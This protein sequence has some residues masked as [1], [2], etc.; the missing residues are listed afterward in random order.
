MVPK[1]RARYVTYGLIT[2]LIQP[3]KKRAKQDEVSSGRGQSLLPI[4]HRNADRRPTYRQAA[5]QQHNIDARRKI[6]HNGYQEF[7]FVHAN[8]PIRIHVIETLG[9]AEGCHRTLEV[10]QHRNPGRV[11][12]M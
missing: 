4:Q 12:I 2:C 9:Y 1:E 8:V 7:L 6:L 3:E 5:H 10:T 11:C